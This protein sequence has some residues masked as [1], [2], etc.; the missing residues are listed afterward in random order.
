M[1]GAE[2]KRRAL[3]VGDKKDG[4]YTVDELRSS[5]IYG[6]TE[7]IYRYGLEEH[8]EPVNAANRREHKALLAKMLKLPGLPAR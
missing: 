6:K 1:T 5:I 7:V 4:V 8:R 2:I 3:E